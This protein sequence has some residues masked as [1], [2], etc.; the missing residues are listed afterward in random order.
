M[1]AAIENQGH[2]GV[3]HSSYPMF[4]VKKGPNI[5]KASNSKTSITKIF[6]PYA[7]AS[8]TYYILR[9]AWYRLG[10]VVRL[11]AHSDMAKH[12]SAGTQ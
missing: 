9:F 2:L 10:I 11:V 1:K 7:S 4:L 6:R 8:I 12:G 5:H 3:K